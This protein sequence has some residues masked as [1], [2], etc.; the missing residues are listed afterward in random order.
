MG[1]Q[2]PHGDQ[3]PGHV[4]MD[5]GD[6]DQGGVDHSTMDHSL[7][8]GSDRRFLQVPESMG[9]TVLHT[10]GMDGM[11]GTD[12]MNG[13]NTSSIPPSHPPTGDADMSAMDPLWMWATL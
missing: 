12:G 1:N 7:N 2:D 4:D 9:G 3:A 6:L 13:M 5:N 11:D 8:L 10:D